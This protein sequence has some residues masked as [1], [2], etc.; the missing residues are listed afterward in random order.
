M[1]A[2]YEMTKN[3]NSPTGWVLKVEDTDGLSNMPTIGEV[4]MVAAKSGK[5][6]KCQV[7]TGIIPTKSGKQSWTH[8]EA[9]CYFVG[10]NRV[11]DPK[12]VKAAPVKVT[13]ASKAAAIDPRDA[14]IAELLAKV[15]SLTEMVAAV[16]ANPKVEDAKTS[17]PDAAT[18]AAHEALKSARPVKSTRARKATPLDMTNAAS[19][20]PVPTRNGTARKVPCFKCGATGVKLLL[21]R[22]G[23]RLC[24]PCL[25]VVE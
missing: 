1:T 19:S 5:L 4:I 15:D 25:D 16:T 17:S 12:A 10:Y 3:G 2:T 21:N 18:V 11:E 8:G 6:T 24:D 7:A 23:Q 9:T 22:D 20:T 13:K 14:V